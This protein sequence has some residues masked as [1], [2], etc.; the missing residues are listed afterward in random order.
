MK[1]D[2][3]SFGR[4]DL[5]RLPG[6]PGAIRMSQP[7]RNLEDLDRAAAAGRASL[8][9][10]RLKIL[11]GSASC[12]M[13]LGAREVEAAAIEAV[14]R[15][16]ARR[17][18]LPHRLH[19]LLRQEPLLDL[20]LPNG[21]RVSYGQHD[22]RKDPPAVEGLRGRKSAPAVGPGP[23]QQRR[24]S[25]D[26][27]GPPISRRPARP[28]QRARV[29]HARFLPPAEES[30]SA[31]LRLDRSADAGRGHRPR[32]LSRGHSGDRRK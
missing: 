30:H 29:V 2:G 23:L 4:V 19:R 24:A 14:R 21:P 27:R 12:G 26:R 18:G 31:E 8:Y 7:I 13:A 16:G 11:I 22:G 25:L 5:D 10:S 20:M 3:R 15:A 6:H 17:R 1:I 9:P 28:R 32:R